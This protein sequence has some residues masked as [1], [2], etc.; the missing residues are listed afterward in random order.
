M[1]A[2]NKHKKTITQNISRMADGIYNELKRQVNALNFKYRCRIAWR[3]IRGK[4]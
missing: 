3:I 4:W 1:S 2:L